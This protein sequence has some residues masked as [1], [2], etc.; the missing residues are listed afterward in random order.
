MMLRSVRTGLL[1]AGLT[2]LLVSGCSRKIKEFQPGVVYKPTDTVA[3]VDGQKMT[4]DQAEKRARNYLKEE[5]DSKRLFIPQG[6]EE[7]A[8]EFFRRKALTLFVNK[9]IMV[10]EAKR[11][12]I[13]VTP[14]DRQKFVTEMETLLKDRNIAPSLEE[15]FKKSPLG[16]KETRR[17]FEDGLLVDKF[18]QEAVRNK[19]TVAD[20]DR[21]ALVT[22]IIAKRREAKLKADELRAQLAKSGDFAAMVKD[23]MKGEDK[24]VVGG[25]LGDVVRGRLGDKLVEDAVFSQ[26]INEN[27]PV[28]DTV[29]GYMLIRVTARTA[30]K[31]AAGAT[32]AVPETV[33]ASFINVR[34]LPLLKGKELDRMI[35][36]RKFS[37]DMMDLLKSLQSKAKIETIYKNLSF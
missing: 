13:A 27:G 21:E 8:M 9:T 5:V 24:R 2:L 15:F 19:I 10:A 29:R 18:I 37:K 6:G 34:T 22:E 4:W 1:F 12:G 17:E 35:Q 28:L 14:A 16:E 33:R 30:A 25:D 36:E 31:P 23:C 7:K 20:K 26:K 32:P 3:R 11:R